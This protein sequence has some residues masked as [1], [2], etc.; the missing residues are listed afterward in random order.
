MRR[1]RA[2]PPSTSRSGRPSHGTSSRDGAPPIDLIDGD[3]LCDLLKK[4]DLGL[5]T[6]VRQV[7][8][9]TVN[10]EFYLEV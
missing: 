6:T 3:G 1:E 8:E 10:S 7:E 9:I 4:Y 2:S 5:T